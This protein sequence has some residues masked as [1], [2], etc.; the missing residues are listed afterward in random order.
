MMQRVHFWRDKLLDVQTSLESSVMSYALGPMRAGYVIRIPV[1]LADWLYARELVRH[2]K[3]EFTD[4][5][6]VLERRR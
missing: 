1:F 4:E 3:E 5:L 6:T 2:D